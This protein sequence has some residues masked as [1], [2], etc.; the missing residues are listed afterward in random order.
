MVF[1]TALSGLLLL[2]ITSSAIFYAHPL[3]ASWLAFSYPT[4]HQIPSVELGTSAIATLLGPL[5]AITANLVYP[6]TA[7]ELH[8]FRNRVNNSLERLLYRATRR[9][10]MVMITLD[11][12][13]VYCGYVDWIPGSPGSTDAYLEILPVFS[14]YRDSDRRVALPTS[15]GPVLDQLG[16]AERG[17]FKK[18]VPVARILSAGEFDPNHFGAFTKTQSDKPRSVTLAPEKAVPSD[19]GAAPL[20]AGDEAGPTKTGTDGESAAP[21][22]QPA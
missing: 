18:V 12:N 1:R 5:L 13:K 22:P 17:Q 14:G 4:A 9:K 15:Y 10:K 2:A 21:T 16:D 7:V 6:R 11:D 19:R 3:T 20:P 8:L